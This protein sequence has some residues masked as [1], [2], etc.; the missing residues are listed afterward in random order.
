MRSSR[1]SFL[2]GA[3]SAAAVGVCRAALPRRTP[4][5]DSHVHVWAAEPRFPFAESAKVPPGLD[6]SV[7]TLLR[8]MNANNV[9]R[10]V[11]IQ[12][13][14]YKYDNRYL[15]DCLDRF[16]GKFAGV[17]RVNPEDPNAPDAL[18][19]W[20]GQGC[21]GVRLSPAADATGD[22]IRGPLMAPLWQRCE[23]LRVPMTLLIPSSRLPDV[24]P[25]I[26]QHPELT[27]VIDHMADCPVGDDTALAKLTAFARY[28]R[29]F[30]K[31]THMWSLSKQP[32]PFADTDDM[33][34]RVRDAF[35]SQRIMGGTDWPIRP[36]L[37][38]YEQRLALY[39]DH[40]PFLNAEERKDVLYRTVQRVW[41]L[42]VA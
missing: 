19:A 22:W 4:T 12:V 6:A 41:P 27:V 25:L 39:R 17:C 14:H 37:V 10:T 35:G 5:I 20:T 2:A 21:H 8:R 11:L 31:I 28:P 24:A 33:V 30:V 32:Y 29:V 40:L 38:S 13:I 7:E 9:A 36:E 42:G 26:E 34:A 3:A 16:P 18:S 15:V 23:Q 1:R